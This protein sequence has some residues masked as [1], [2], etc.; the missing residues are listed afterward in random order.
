MDQKHH[1]TKIVSTQLGWPTDA[2]TLE[3]NHVLLWQN[4]RKKS[5]GGM[6]LTDEGFATFTEKMDMKSYDIEFPK[7]FT[8]TN[9]VTIWLDRFVDGPYYITKKSIVVF[10]E[11]TA[12]QLIL[13]SGDVQ[14][15]GMAK[16]MSL[17]NNTEEIG[18]TTD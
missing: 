18:Q 4:P 14:K 12:V 7:E 13:F 5:Q 3:K 8:L 9:Q 11:K 10:K 1:L 16:A 2:K 6:R 17:K 15:F